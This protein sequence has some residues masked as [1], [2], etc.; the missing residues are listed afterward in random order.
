MAEQKK[1][2]GAK[3]PAKKRASAGK[4]RGAAET[5]ASKTRARTKA[6]QAK[7][8]ETKASRTTET[9]VRKPRTSRRAAARKE[10]EQHGTAPA[11]SGSASLFDMAPGLQPASA[12]RVEGPTAQL[13]TVSTATAAL[14]APA[15]RLVDAAA[16]Q[17]L[18]A[19]A[20]IQTS[21][22][23]LRNAV[24]ETTTAATSTVLEVNGK[25]IDA[26]R[27]QS[28]AAIEL[29]RSTMSAGSLSEV[30]RL[31]TSGARQAYETA[32]NHWKDVAET[33]TRWFSAAIKPLQSALTD[34]RQ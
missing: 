34:R 19:H 18:Q 28:D 26:V 14:A 5:V 2:A 22:A 17:T 3:A 13:R 9:Q 31:Q 1:S 21:N 25:V 20:R 33:T 16:E 4:A 15:A 12:T 6:S 27:A 32:A 8:S 23:A 7:V 30:V 10:L 24:S 29:W 11:T